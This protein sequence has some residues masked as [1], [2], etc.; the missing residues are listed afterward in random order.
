LSGSDIGLPAPA[1]LA[2]GPL[3]RIGTDRVR[4][5]RQ[6]DGSWAFNYSITKLEAPD[7]AEILSG[8][9][10]ALEAAVIPL[11]VSGVELTFSRPLTGEAQVADGAAAF[12]A[13]VRDCATLIDRVGPREPTRIGI[14]W[15]PVL[16]G[17]T[18]VLNDWRLDLD[19]IRAEVS[20]AA[21]R[22]YADLGGWVDGLDRLILQLDHPGA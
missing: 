12:G 1:P 13:F 18:D 5:L 20:A 14:F 9:V 21:G 8:W 15:S 7:L 22:L 17:S 16:R 6:E 3:A 10:P 19:P 4:C 11:R 2:T